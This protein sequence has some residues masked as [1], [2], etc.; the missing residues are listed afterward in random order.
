MHTHPGPQKLRDALSA[1]DRTPSW[2]ARK[3]GV[4][5]STVTRWINASMR[6][7]EG[8]RGDLQAMF[9]IAPDDWGRR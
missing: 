5:P 1:D 2:L 8:Q 3:I 4:S 9:G 7:S 6:P